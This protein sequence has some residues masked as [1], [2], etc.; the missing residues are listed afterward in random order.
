MADESKPHNEPAGLCL[1]YAPSGRNGKATVTARLAGDVLAVESFDLTR[2]KARRDFATAVAD[3]RPGIDQAAVESEL[4]RAAADQA[5][6]ARDDGATDTPAHPDPAELLKAMPEHV[7]AAARAMLES[8]DL[9]ERIGEDFS[10]VGI[11]GERTLAGT[12]YLSGVSRLLERPLALL[13][14]GPS[15]SGKSLVLGAVAKLF[16]PEAVFSATTL[17][18]LSLYYAPPGTFRHRFVVCGERSRKTDEDQAEVTRALRELLSEGRLSR[19]VTVKKHDGAPASEL[20]EQEGPI[21]YAESTTLATSQVFTEDLNR[22]LLLATDETPE[23]TRRVLHRLAEKYDHGACG[24]PSGVVEKHHAAQRMLRTMRVRIPY[25][26]ALMDLLPSTRLE[27]RRGAGYV[28]AMIEASAL[29][30]QRQRQVTGDGDLLATLD[31]YRVA[32]ALLSQ[33]LGRLLGRQVSEGALRFLGRLVEWFGVGG[34]Y[35]IPEARGRETHSVSGVYGWNSDLAGSGLVELVEQ[36]RGNAP[37]RWKV[38]KSPDEASE[39]LTLLP[40][41]EELEHIEP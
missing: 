15:S 7:Q 41:A 30:H 35:S 5:C 32:R 26:R 39:S 29:L 3:G 21:A 19:L 8:P 10:A 12:V 27:I 9:L 6:R 17:S 16:P 14:Q 33:P 24:D 22:M 20:V 28:L 18:T 13:V 23:Q 40:E 11:A 38:A 2:S 34:E 31:D 25:A 1:E 37:A 4:L 36:K